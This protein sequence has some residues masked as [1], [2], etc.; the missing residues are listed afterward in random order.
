M[1]TELLEFIVNWRT[2]LVVLLVFGFAPG[3]LLRLIV[4]AFRRDDPRRSE[5]LAEL[6]RVPRLERPLWVV[7]QMEVALFEGIWGRVVWV[8]TGRIIYRWYLDSG[9][10]RNR[11]HPESYW[12]PDEHEKQAIAPGV[13]VKLMFQIDDLRGRHLWG[14]G[15][16]VKVLA[17][18]KRRI[19]G[20]L[21]NEPLAIPRLAVGDPVK[22]KR[23]HIIDIDWDSKHLREPSKEAPESRDLF[24]LPLPGM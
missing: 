21:L 4:L 10:K 3:A 1:V 6:H 5:M 8:A 12:I 19:V 2:G 18:E 11:K 23:D 17:V 7:E 24:F 16:W 22:F 9:V 15:M 14:E 13:V 20:R